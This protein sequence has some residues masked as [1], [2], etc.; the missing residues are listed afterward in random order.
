[1]TKKDLFES[2][3]ETNKPTGATSTTLNDDKLNTLVDTIS[4][5]V[6]PK[7]FEVNP[8]ESIFEQLKNEQEGK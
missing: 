3:Q 8:E 1:M 2:L 4:Q 5:P 7:K 6:R